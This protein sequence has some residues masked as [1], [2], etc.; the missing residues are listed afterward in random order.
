MKINE[1]IQ[2]GI[3]DDIKSKSQSAAQN[4]KT[5]YQAGRQGLGKIPQRTASGQMAPAG[6]LGSAANYAG[7]KVRSTQRA[8]TAAK[9]GARNVQDIYR[10][11]QLGKAE[12]MGASPEEY[13]WIQRGQFAHD[14]GSA[15]NKYSGG[16]GSF[17]TPASKPIGPNQHPITV[18][19]QVGNQIVDVECDNSRACYL[20][21]RKL[22]PADKNDA[23]IIQ[24]VQKQ[25]AGQA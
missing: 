12:K 5:N 10:S 17:Y 3:W 18:K 7:S 6:A 4:V 25:L 19:T 11:N 16:G 24:A 2:E 20:G 22:N 15:I 21:G 8:A 9:V 14:I 13:K 23:L 1:I